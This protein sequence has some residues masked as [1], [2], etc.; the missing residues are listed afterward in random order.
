VCAQA[1]E[2]IKLRPKVYEPSS[3]WWNTRRL[4][5]KQELM[6]AVWPDAFV[7]RRF[8]GAVYP[9]VARALDDRSQQLLKTVPRRGYCFTAEGDPT[10][11]EDRS[12]PSN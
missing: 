11:N 12:F 7:Y 6:Q 8:A 4:I 2:E 9:R 3:T 5:G 10:R 1:G